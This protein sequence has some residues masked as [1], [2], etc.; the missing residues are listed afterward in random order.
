MSSSK[1]A[2]CRNFI[3]IVTV[4]SSSRLKIDTPIF[5]GNVGIGTSTGRVALD[6]L[7]TS[8]ILAPVGTEQQRPSGMKG[9]LRYNSTIDA[10]EGYSG[11]G[12]W[13]S[14]GISGIGITGV[15]ASDSWTVT[16]NNT[17]GN[18][19]IY[20][21]PAYDIASVYTKATPF[22]TSATAITTS[23]NWPSGT[24]WSVSANINPTTAW[25][26]FKNT[27]GEWETS[28][29]DASKVV[30]D[31]IYV[32]YPS[33]NKLYSVAITSFLDTFFNDTA[34]PNT[35]Y[36]QGS[37]NN[38]LWIHVQ[39]FSGGTWSSGNART[40]LI[41]EPHFP[42]KYWRVFFATNA[43]AARKINI[44]TIRFNTILSNGR[45]S[46]V[47]PISSS[48]FKIVMTDVF[49]VPINM[50]SWPVVVKYNIMITKSNSVVLSGLYEFNG[51]NNTVTKLS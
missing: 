33:A 39:T 35:F 38:S 7:S 12:T 30:D 25:N 13:T 45:L 5:T 27:G 20:V 19:Q 9:L 4:D 14:I 49:G 37:Y 36:I 23:T 8:A 47:Y 29:S 46:S 16:T 34:F 11:I 51:N 40:F 15:L 31:Y 28:A 22:F 48:Q 6:I 43:T 2:I 10:F 18:L 3:E 32:E 1:K 24:G 42:Y 50:T 21:T 26:P 41:T 44:Q 17:S